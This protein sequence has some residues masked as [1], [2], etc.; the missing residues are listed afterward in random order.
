MSNL[1]ETKA[2]LV[3]EQKALD[4]NIGK[5]DKFLVSEAGVALNGCDTNLLKEQKVAMTNYSKI[6]G[7]RIGRMETAIAAE[8]RDARVAKAAE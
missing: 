7:K 6:L 2:R 4:D 3:K 8:E 5:I 1:K